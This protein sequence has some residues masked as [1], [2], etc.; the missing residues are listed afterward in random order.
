MYSVVVPVYR[1]EGSIPTLLEALAEMGAKLDGPLEVVF[2]VDGSPDGSAELLQRLLPEQTFRAQLLL[3]SRNFG[4]FN[5]IRAGLEHATGPF[6]AV[7]AADLQEPPELILEFFELLRADTVDVV[8]GT[9][10][11]RDDPWATRLASRV[12]W[13]F[14]RRVVDK[15]MPSGGVDVFGCNDRFRQRLLG[16]NEANSSLVG[17]LFWLGFRRQ[18]VPYD[19]RRREHGQSAWT[20]R[21]KLRYLANSIFSFTDLPVRLLIGLGAVGLLLSVVFGGVVLV[22]TITGLIGVPGYSATVL[23]VTFFGALNCFGLGVIG[24]Y[25]W[26]AY[27]NTKQRPHWEVMLTETYGARDAA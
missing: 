3:L 7:L 1:N 12:F 6:F 24:S 13:G 11:T 16:L 19:R 10:R 5:A 26:R 22:S 18:A 8:V 21:R 15:A 27:E 17:Q 23:T 4:A 14:Y 2:V 20:F 9:R 25:V